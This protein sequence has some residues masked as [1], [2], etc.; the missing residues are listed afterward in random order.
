MEINIFKK[1]IL[2]VSN[3]G[4][5]VLGL[6][7]LILRILALDFHLIV[8]VALVLS[9]REVLFQKLILCIKILLLAEFKLTS[10]RW[11]YLSKVAINMR[12]QLLVIYLLAFSLFMEIKEKVVLTLRYKKLMPIFSQN[13]LIM[14]RLLWMD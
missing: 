2:M 4:K 6:T 12:Q 7:Q 10:F 9:G 5:R 3:N 1:L 11:L 14:A 13:G 8:M